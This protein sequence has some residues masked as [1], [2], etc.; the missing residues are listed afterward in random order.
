MAKCISGNLSAYSEI[1]YRT[2]AKAGLVGKATVDFDAQYCFIVGHCENT[3]VNDT[4]NIAEGEKMCDKR[5]GRRHNGPP[6][7]EFSMMDLAKSAA[8]SPLSGGMNLAFTVRS[9]LH[10]NLNRNF[11][12]SF[13]KLACAMGNYHCDA[14]YC[15]LKYCKDPYYRSK[16]AV[17]RVASTLDVPW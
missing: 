4:T 3:A 11:A 8:L 16:Y 5:Y 12:H 6:W 9:P 2:Q 7:Y 1:M 13:A 15:Q 17:K 14:R 10:L